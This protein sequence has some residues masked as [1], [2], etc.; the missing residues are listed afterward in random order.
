MTTDVDLPPLCHSDLMLARRRVWPYA[1]A[2][3]LAATVLATPT[4]PMAAEPPAGHTQVAMAISLSSETRELSVQSAAA[5]ITTHETAV[6]ITQP[7]GM[8]AG[9]DWSWPTLL[10]A[11]VAALGWQ[12]VRHRPGR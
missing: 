7:A 3:V 11:C 8:V 1:S 12:V 4:A 6:S 10:L 9:S 5:P 2:A